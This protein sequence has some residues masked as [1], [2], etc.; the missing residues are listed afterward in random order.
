[1]IN[2]C[3][4]TQARVPEPVAKKEGSLEKRER[5]REGEDGWE[6]KKGQTI[7]KEMGGKEEGVQKEEEET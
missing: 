1:M 3:E 7:Q 4:W 5:K 6:E 2:I